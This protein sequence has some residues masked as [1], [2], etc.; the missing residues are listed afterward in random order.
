MSAAADHL[1]EVRR[2]LQRI[3]VH[4]GCIPALLVSE[5]HDDVGL[6]IS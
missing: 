6:A 4:S 5:K 3:A 1:I 2:Q